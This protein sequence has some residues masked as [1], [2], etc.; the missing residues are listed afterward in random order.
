MRKKFLMLIAVMLLLTACGKLANPSQMPEIAFF[1]TCDY[2][3]GTGGRRVS[4]YDKQGNYCW[5]EDKDAASLAFPELMSKYETGEL[6]G[7]IEV[8]SSCDVN[9][10]FENYQKFLTAVRKGNYKIEEPEVLP[11]AETRIEK[12]YGVRSN[13]GTLQLVL[14]HEYSR[15]TNLNSVSDEI[16]EVYMAF[17]G[18]FGQ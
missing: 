13:N 14:L 10:L 7:K 11:A 15:A 18:G 2:N 3:D 5:S 17:K 6:D 9:V 12:W 4:F 8:R 1:C 16:N